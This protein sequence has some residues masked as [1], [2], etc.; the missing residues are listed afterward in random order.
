MPTSAEELL[1]HTRM[2]M[3]QDR[4]FAFTPK[5]ELIQLPKGATPVD[6]AYAVHTDLGDQTVG[7][8]INGRVMPLRT[9]LDNGD[10]VEILRLQGAAAAARL[11][12]LRRHRQ[13]ARRDPPLWCSPRSA[14]RRSRSAARSSTRSSSACPRRSAGRRSP[15]RSS[16]C[17]LP[18][19]DGADGGDRAAADHRRRGDGSADAGL[20]Q[21]ATAA[22]PPPQRT[23]ISIKGL[24]PGRRLPA[25]RMLPPDPGRPHRRPAAARARGS[26]STSSTAPSSPTG[27]TPTGSI[28]PGA[29]ADGGAA[30]LVVDRAR[31]RARWG[32]GGDLRTQARQHRQPSARHRDGSFHT[33]HL[34]VEVHDVHHL[35][36]I[37]AAV[38]DAEPVSSVE[39]VVELGAALSL[40]TGMSVTSRPALQ[41]SRRSEAL[42]VIGAIWN[43]MFEP[44]NIGAKNTFA[45]DFS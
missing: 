28:S 12:E 16:G 22:K 3:Y 38:R 17:K 42:A 13:G 44:K 39:R 8:K 14:R 45:A 34:D 4:I 30:R 25:R 19:D 20:G 27:S 21:H 36:R 35:M 6:F 7:A 10:Q 9:P 40:R 33:F 43:G 37:L 31:S 18:D 2:A 41:A 26:R 32:R 24:T 1:E 15:R 5:G 29:K 23:A 11:A